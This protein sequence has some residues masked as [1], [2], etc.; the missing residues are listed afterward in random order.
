MDETAGGVMFER[1]GIVGLGLIGT[2]FGLALRERGLAGRLIGVD[3]DPRALATASARE[4]IDEGYE[5][6]AALENVDLVI[7]AVP[8]RA[9]VEAVRRA[10]Q[11]A[12]SEAILL[13]VA[14]VKAPIIR[15]LEAILP[16]DTRYI[17]G[18]PMAGTEGRGAAAAGA[19]LLGGR[20]FLIVP[21]ARSDAGAVDTVRAL[22]RALGMRP[23]IIDAGVHDSVVAQVSHVPYLL[24][25]AAVNA[26]DDAALGLGGPAF[27][28]LRRVAGSPVNLWVEICTQNRDA[29]LRSLGWV[30]D[31][32][33]R[34]ERALDDG[35]LAAV[36]NEA[37]RRSGVGG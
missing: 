13:D 28:G 32:L 1:V 2:S 23:L 25:V 37:H 3:P 9:V 22:V 10:A 16:G 31:E 33:D 11:V 12:G 7:I 5:A 6:Y 21:T 8:P 27:D 29:I 26:A 34:L 15:A 24:A 17:G 36:L 19:A 30:R 20:P 18:H 4:A 35:D 14:S